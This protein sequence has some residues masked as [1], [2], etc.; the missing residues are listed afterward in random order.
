MSASTTNNNLRSSCGYY[1]YVSHWYEENKAIFK[2]GNWYLYDI[3][4]WYDGSYSQGL[5]DIK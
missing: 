5:P 1:V 3:Y 4:T 2:L